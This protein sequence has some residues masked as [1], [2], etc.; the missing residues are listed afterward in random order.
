MV[1]EGLATAGVA[2]GEIR[3]GLG[4]LRVGMEAP[5]LGVIAD[6]LPKAPVLAPG[7]LLGVILV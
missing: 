7:P 1:D 2:L 5:P 3:E 6:D 4:A